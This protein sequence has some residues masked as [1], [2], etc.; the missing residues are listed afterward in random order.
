MNDQLKHLLGLVFGVGHRWVARAF[1][2]QI[3]AKG[4]SIDYVVCNMPLLCLR[5]ACVAFCVC[6]GMVA[7]SGRFPTSFLQLD[8]R[9]M[10][11]HV[12]DSDFQPAT[13]SIRKIPNI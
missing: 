1:L 11:M 5:D 13:T 3:G 12:E 10:H 4:L 7:C 6:Q 2:D 8:H 9:F